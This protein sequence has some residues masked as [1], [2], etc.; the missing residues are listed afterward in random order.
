MARDNV[1]ALATLPNIVSLSRLPMAAAFPFLG[2][3]GRLIV[4]AAAATTDFLDGYFARR[5]GDVTKLGALLDP[6][7]DR[8]FV[9]IAVGTLWLEAVFTPLA[10]FVI[11]SRDLSVI[12]A[13]AVTRMMG[14]M[15]NVAFVA[16]PAG[17][18]VTVLQLG[19]LSLAYVAPEL[20]IAGVLLVGV[21]SAA[22]I[23]DYLRYIRRNRAS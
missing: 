19:A 2:T 21:A 1:A 6:I 7:S 5:R 14:T 9:L 8:C 13:F 3:E 18:V 22:A 15:R 23:I 16:R 17:K 10:T 12:G 11:V 20:V 4:I